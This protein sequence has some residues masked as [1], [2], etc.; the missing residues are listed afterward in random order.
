MGKINYKA[1][2]MVAV[3]SFHKDILKNNTLYELCKIFELSNVFIDVYSIENRK[4]NFCELIKSRCKNILL[5]VSG[6]RECQNIH[7]NAS[8]NEISS[9]SLILKDFYFEDIN[10]WDCYTEWEQFLKDKNDYSISVFKKVEIKENNL[11]YLNYKENQVEIICNSSY[12]CR[13][14]KEELNKLL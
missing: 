14:L 8:I 9:I 10:I 12:Y 3:Y 11:F 2:K 6:N 5:A 4:N 13:N 7:L 1:N